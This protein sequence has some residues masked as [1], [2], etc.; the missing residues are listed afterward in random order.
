MST[1]LQEAHVEAVAEAKATKVRINQ[2][3]ARDGRPDAWPSEVAEINAA[4]KKAN[5]IK[6]RIDSM[7]GSANFHAALGSITGGMT[8]G[9]GGAERSLGQ[10]IINSE[11]GQW[12]MKNKGKFPSGAW[13]SPSSELM[14]ATLT[15]DS[16]SG[17]DLIITDYQAGILPLPTRPLVVADLIAPG[18]TTSNA[19]GYMKEVTATNAAA[20]VLEGGTK[21]ESTLIFDAV[22]DPVRKI[23]TWLPVTE[24]MLEDVT[25]L[26][27]YI[28]TRLRH[29]VQ[30]AEDD[31][32]LNGNGTAPNISGILDRPGIAAPMARV[33]ESN[34]DI[35]LK[36]I[37]AIEQAT[38]M[39]VDGIVLHPTN[40]DTM[41]L[42]KTADGKYIAGGGPFETPQR[43]TL[44]GRQVALTPAITLGTSLVGAFRTA[45][46][47]FR[48]G[49]LRVEASNSHSDFFVKNLVAIR[50]EERGALCIYRESA[51]GLVTNLN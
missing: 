40:W 2:V 28:D 31:Q 5:D 27:G 10:Q 9:S 32:L 33:A 24:E 23:A 1:T 12:L 17:G 19:V 13:Q 42:L 51:F 41:L 26:S 6:A 35:I 16:A 34:P 49:A 11:M 29:F 46:Q 39:A 15:S 37:S 44:W 50:A 8:P 4:I 22:T 43:K 30:L 47:F 20:P 25:A 21:P 45:S 3:M 14:A 7:Q 38:S 36:Q 18:T 48:K